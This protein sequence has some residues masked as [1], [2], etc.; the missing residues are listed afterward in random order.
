MERIIFSTFFLA[1]PILSIIVLTTFKILINN[2][3]VW[4]AFESYLP[5]IVFYYVIVSAFWVINLDKIK[6]ATSKE[7]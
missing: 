2:S 5:I 4:I 7:N 3:N 6:K 1:I